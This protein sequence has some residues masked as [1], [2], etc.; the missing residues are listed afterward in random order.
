LMPLL[1]VEALSASA[2]VTLIG[3]VLAWLALDFARLFVGGPLLNFAKFFGRGEKAAFD[4]GKESE[5]VVEKSPEDG[6]AKNG[7]EI[8]SD[9][10]NGD[11]KQEEN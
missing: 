4:A 7:G 3:I 8:N 5:T 1:S 10:P 2:A 9:A 6:D 11:S